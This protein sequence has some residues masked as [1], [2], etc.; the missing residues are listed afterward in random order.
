MRP[1]SPVTPVSLSTVTGA[2]AS[3]GAPATT[4]GGEIDSSGRVASAMPEAGAGAGALLLVAALPDDA[5][6][7]A[8]LTNE[9]TP[10]T[11]SATTATATR[12]MIMRRGERFSSRSSPAR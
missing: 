7:V 10:S 8:G 12:A 2:L 1:A 11:P 6:L 5:S 9:Y 3:A 4:G